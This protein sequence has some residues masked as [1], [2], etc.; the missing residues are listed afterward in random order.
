M[1]V[2]AEDFGYQYKYDDKNRCIASKLPGADWT[3]H[4]YDRHDR[5]PS[6]RTETMG[7]QFIGHLARQQIQVQ[8]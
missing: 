5:L 1:I 6:R 7:Q 2:I 4:I 8:R 3:Y